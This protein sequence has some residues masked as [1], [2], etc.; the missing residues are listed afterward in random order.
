MRYGHTPDG[1]AVPSAV[2]LAWLLSV[3]DQ[4][5]LFTAQALYF[6]SAMACHSF[7]V[8]KKPR[9]QMAITGSS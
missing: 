6:L 8:Y 1:A 5:A 4:P 9:W 3:I 7:R 2:R